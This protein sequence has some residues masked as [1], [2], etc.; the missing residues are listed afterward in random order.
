MNKE[1]ILKLVNAGY[2]KAEIEAMDSDQKPEE[3]PE[4]KPEGKPE[5]KPEVKPAETVSFSPEVMKEFTGAI[6][7][8]SD[9]IK[10]SNMINDGYEPKTALEKGEEVLA[11]LINPPAKEK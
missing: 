2:T 11:S 3:K 1:E 4:E 10:K 9:M 5:E 8:L 7:G 6:N